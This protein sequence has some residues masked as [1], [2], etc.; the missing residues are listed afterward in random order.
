MKREQGAAL[1]GEIPNVPGRETGPL[2]Q[3]VAG[4]GEDV[5]GST[6]PLTAHPGLHPGEFEHQELDMPAQQTTEPLP[7]ATSQTP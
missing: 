5:P 1:N 2:R 4:S 6:P 7:I 3:H